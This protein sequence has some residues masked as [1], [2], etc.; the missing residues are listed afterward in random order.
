[1]SM[2]VPYSQSPLM[3]PLPLETCSYA[4][5][6]QQKLQATKQKLKRSNSK[7]KIESKR[8]TY[9]KVDKVD[10]N[11]SMTFKP[12]KHSSSNK[13]S[14]LGI[15][16]ESKI[17]N[18][19]STVNTTKQ[20]KRDH[21]ENSSTSLHISSNNLNSPLQNNK[22]PKHLSNKFNETV[23]PPLQNTKPLKTYSD[24]LKT[25]GIKILGNG[26]ANNVK[27]I[28]MTK[29]N[30]ARNTKSVFIDLDSAAEQA[31][32]KSTI[33]QNK[34][35]EKKKTIPLSLNPAILLSSCP[36]LSITPVMN[37]NDNIMHRKGLEPS[38]SRQIQNSSTSNNFNFEQQFQHLS[39]SLTI[40][41]TE[42][43]A[44]NKI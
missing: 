28:V 35:P 21:L 38:T 9:S 34:S 11:R 37:A 41:K 8:S 44:N 4:Y 1:M 42:K 19:K 24:K 16:K 32:L 40:T 13:F 25:S 20:P 36:G 18:Q 39:N 3:Y 30:M 12:K 15:G 6:L 23:S 26:N 31:R 43:N 7:Q 29:V 10:T 33:F 2:L 17:K 22:L 14:S 27:P 5:T